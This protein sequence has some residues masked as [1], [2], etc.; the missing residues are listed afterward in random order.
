MNYKEQ[1]FE[2]IMYHLLRGPEKANTE[3]VGIALK[4][5]IIPIILL[6]ILLSIPLTFF[7]FCIY[8]FWKYMIE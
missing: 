7:N 4:V 8:Y 6:V 5:C 3:V 2:T 1:T